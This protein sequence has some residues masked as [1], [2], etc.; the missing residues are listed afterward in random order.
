MPAG[1]IAKLPRTDLSAKWFGC[2]IWIF[3]RIALITLIQKRRNKEKWLITICV[4]DIIILLSCKST[5]ETLYESPS[6]N[7]RSNSKKTDRHFPQAV[8]LYV[9]SYMILPVKISEIRQQ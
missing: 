1:T 5:K 3:E 4:P 8:V 7:L 2:S 9:R 6:D